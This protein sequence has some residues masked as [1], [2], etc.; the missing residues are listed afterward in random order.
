MA[1]RPRGL[2]PRA[3]ACIFHKTHGLMLYLLH[4]YPLLPW[5]LQGVAEGY[6]TTVADIRGAY[7]PS[8]C[9]ISDLYHV[10]AAL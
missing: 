8:R 6:V 7:P 1:T 5:L 10:T 2:R 9:G 4:I 3:R